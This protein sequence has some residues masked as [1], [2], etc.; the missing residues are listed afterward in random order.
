MFIL[1]LNGHYRSS[2]IVLLTAGFDQFYTT[3]ILNTQIVM[4]MIYIN[5]YSIIKY[6]VILL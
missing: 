4:M 5:K 2:T 6:Y 3:A 1:N